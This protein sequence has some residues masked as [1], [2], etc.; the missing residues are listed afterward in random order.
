MLEDKIKKREEAEQ[1]IY[2]YYRRHR[3]EERLFS[4]QKKDWNLVLKG[5]HHAHL[6]WGLSHFENDY[7]LYYVHGQTVKC[8]SN[9]E[10]VHLTRRLSLWRRKW[11]ELELKQL[12]PNG[13]W[14]NWRGHF[15]PEITTKTFVL[16]TLRATPSFN[17]LFES[18]FRI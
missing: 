1:Q 10:M 17:Y 9:E 5:K 15:W 7:I 16:A 14:V 11:V 18:A 3:R 13:L 4:R 6:K 8:N 12:P 2:W